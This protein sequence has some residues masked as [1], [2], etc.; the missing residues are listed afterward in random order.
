MRGK[1]YVL[2]LE[3]LPQGG[4][5]TYSSFNSGHGTRAARRETYT[6]ES[7]SSILVLCMQSRLLL[8]S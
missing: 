8:T 6:Y 7:M 3:V 4:G 5:V 2:G 1:M